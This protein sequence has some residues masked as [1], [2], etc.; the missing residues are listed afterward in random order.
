MYFE[1]ETAWGPALNDRELNADVIQCFVAEIRD[2]TPGQHVAAAVL[3]EAHNASQG[4][5]LSKC[6]SGELEVLCLK[7]E[8]RIKLLISYL[9]LLTRKSRKS[10]SNKIQNFKSYIIV[11]DYKWTWQRLLS[12]HGPRVR[13]IAI[14]LFNLCGDQTVLFTRVRL[15]RISFHKHCKMLPFKLFNRIQ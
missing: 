14:W 1:K 13:P 12:A 9:R 5:L 4:Q 2:R 7:L 3:V 15:A 6:R 8:G 11:R 10:D